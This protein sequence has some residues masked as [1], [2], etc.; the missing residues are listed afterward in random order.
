MEMSLPSALVLLFCCFFY[1]S[2]S[3]GRSHS[4]QTLPEVKR[5]DYYFERKAYGSGGDWRGD[6]IV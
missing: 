1:E 6:L 5:Y 4:P 2:G 3:A